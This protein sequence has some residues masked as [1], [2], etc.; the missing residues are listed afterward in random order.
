MRRKFQTQQSDTVRC[1]GQFNS[2]KVAQRSLR[3]GADARLLSERSR[4]PKPATQQPPSDLSRSVY[5]VLGIPIDAI[6]MATVVH[7][8]E[9]AAAN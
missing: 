9:A 2:F 8:M 6:N 7:R 3:E 5:C 1:Q 4:S